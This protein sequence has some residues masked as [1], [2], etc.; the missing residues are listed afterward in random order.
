MRF[1][2]ISFYKSCMIMHALFDK[3]IHPMSHD[4]VI[5][6]VPAVHIRCAHSV[7]RRTLARCVDEPQ[8]DFAEACPRFERQ[9]HSLH[10]LGVRTQRCLEAGPGTSLPAP[11]QERSTALSPT[12][13]LMFVCSRDMTTSF[14]FARERCQF[15]RLVMPTRFPWSV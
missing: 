4:P 9:A 14:L 13:S 6:P 1:Y 3:E 12:Y 7:Q 11:C 8:G 15:V 10:F 2:I 5:W